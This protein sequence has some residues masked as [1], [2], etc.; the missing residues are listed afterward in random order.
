ME[1]T[2]LILISIALFLLVIIVGLLAVL[3][4]KFLNQNGQTMQANQNDEVVNSL[5]ETISAKNF[6]PEIQNR[7]R[8]IEKIKKKKSDFF[9]PNHTEEVGEVTCAICDTLFCKSCVKPF[10]NLHFCKEHLPLIMK[11]DWVEVLTVK[12]STTDPEEGVRL[13]DAKKDIFQNNDLPTYIET[14]YK[15][16]VDQDF[17]ETYLVLYSIREKSEEIR[18]KLKNFII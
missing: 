12:T 10:K 8:E 1:Q 7:L 15:I 17:I 4:L 5:N 13:Y 2:A 14:H 3:I 18:Q 11:F 9:C 6:H 16:N